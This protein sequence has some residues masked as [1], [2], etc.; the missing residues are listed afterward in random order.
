MK[1]IL[2]LLTILFTVVY[3]S[4]VGAA[5]NR[6]PTG[7]VQDL[8]QT[9]KNQNLP[10]GL[11]Y[12]DIHGLSQYCLAQHWNERSNTEKEN[13][14][15]LLGDL[16]VNVAFKKSTG[17]FEDINIEYQE[18]NIHQNKAGVLT[19][20][21]HPDEGEIEIEYHLQRVNNQWLIHDVLLDGVSLATNL[22]SQMIQVIQENSYEE[23]VKKMK[24]KLEAEP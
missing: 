16:L 22:R 8:I 14:I 24:E 23:L 9:I 1:R 20:V 11:S 15:K 18:E 4:H 5:T 21:E 2:L 3:L 17:F 10:K 7:V 12:V 13:F 6:N 19:I